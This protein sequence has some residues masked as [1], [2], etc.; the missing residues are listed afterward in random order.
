MVSYSPL[1]LHQLLVLFAALIV[2][3]LEVHGDVS[4][5]EA[6]HAHIVGFQTVGVLPGLKGL[7]QDYVGGVLGNHD[8]LVHAPSFGWKAPCVVCVELALVN[9]L[10]VKVVGAVTW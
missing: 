7:D 3:D 1:L 8:V 4:V 6:V 2:K 10:H 9:G 5:L